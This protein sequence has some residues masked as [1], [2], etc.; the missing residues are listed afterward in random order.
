M[1]G[2]YA[3][4]RGKTCFVLSLS[5]S[6]DAVQGTDLLVAFRPGAD[7]PAPFQTRRTLRYMRDVQRFGTV[8]PRSPVGPIT[9]PAD[10]FMLGRSAAGP[11]EITTDLELVEVNSPD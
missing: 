11:A 2:C 9:G 4:P 3:V 5:W 1:I 6:R 7:E 10:L 8:V